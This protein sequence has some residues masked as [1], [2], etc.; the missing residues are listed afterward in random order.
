MEKI[1]AI[2]PLFFSQYIY[3][4]PKMAYFSSLLWWNIFQT[5][6]LSR[7]ITKSK[8]TS[9]LS[10][11]QNRIKLRWSVF[12]TQSKTKLHRWHIMDLLIFVSSI[13]FGLVCSGTIIIIFITI[14]ISTVGWHRLREGPSAKSLDS[15]ENFK[16]WHT[17]FCRNIEMSRNLHIS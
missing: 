9:N 6:G 8:K 15:D 7:A 3:V 1:Q 12:L 17:P 4:S 5:L 11:Y 14:I 13:L 16:P 2:T 10:K